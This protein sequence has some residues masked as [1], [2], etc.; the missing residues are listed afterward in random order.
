MER[1]Y[2]NKYGFYGKSLYTA[3]SL[4]INM[5][6]LIYR[7]TGR[8]YYFLA[9]VTTQFE[10]LQWSYQKIYLARK[11]SWESALLDGLTIRFL[12]INRYASEHSI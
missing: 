8:K 6:K 2:M 9:P 4:L 11:R 3:V 5:S 12:A 7:K 10:L 1:S